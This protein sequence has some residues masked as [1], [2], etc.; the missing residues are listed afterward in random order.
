MKSHE[1]DAI[2]IYLYGLIEYIYLSRRIHY[3]PSQLNSKMNDSFLRRSYFTLNEKKT[4][5]NVL[6]T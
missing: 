1:F 6:G 3:E 5:I 2:L 4:L